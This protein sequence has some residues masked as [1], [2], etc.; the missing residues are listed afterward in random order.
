MPKEFMSSTFSKNPLFDYMPENDKYLFRR[1]QPRYKFVVIGAGMIGLEHIKCTLLEGRAE[2]IGI[3]DVSQ[4]SIEKTLAAC[5]EIMPGKRLKV[6]NDLDGACSDP[7]ADALLITTPNFSHVQVLRTAVKYGK[8]IF[9]EKPM[10]TTLDDA[11]E[12]VKI[13]NGYH[14]TLQIGLQY[15]YKAIYAEA[16]HE[17]LERRSLGDIKTLFIMEHRVPFLDKVS[18]WNK[19][20][21]YSGGTFVEK[22]CHYFDLFNLFAQSRPKS[23]YAVGSQAVNYKEFEFKGEKSDIVDNGSAIVTYENG[24]VATFHLCMFAPMFY[25]ELVICGTEGRLKTYENEDYLPDRRP[26]TFLEVL[27]GEGGKPSKVMTPCYPDVV[28]ASGHHGG[29]FYEHMY[30]IDNMDGKKTQTATV[31]E[32]FW[33]VVVGCAAEESVRKGGIVDIKAMLTEHNIT[34]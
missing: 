8:H 27:H 31:E 6:Y 32:G 25:E 21:K 22:C 2:I 10:S 14:K 9:M 24:V 12:I 29:T 1:A 26:Q 23:V 5:G 28:Q 15:R 11:A 17:A 3:Y 13:A 7:A 33:S 20:S 4:L 30:L 18:Q 19:F 34:I 16:C